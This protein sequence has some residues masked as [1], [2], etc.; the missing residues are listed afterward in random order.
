MRATRTAGQRLRDWRR[1]HEWSQ[2]ELARR[3]GVSEMNIYRWETD[4]AKPPWSLL[5]F[6]L[7]ALDHDAPWHEIEQEVFGTNDENDD[8]DEQ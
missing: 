6:S 4:A 8:A 3:L 5:A 7:W 2:R 1:A